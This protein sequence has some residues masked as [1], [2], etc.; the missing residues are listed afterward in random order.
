MEREPSQAILWTVK[1]IAS[2]SRMVWVLKKYRAKMEAHLPEVKPMRASLC[3]RM[4]SDP[5]CGDKEG[6]RIEHLL[7]MNCAF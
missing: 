4:R 5:G 7:T 3:N 6:E 2:S 1:S